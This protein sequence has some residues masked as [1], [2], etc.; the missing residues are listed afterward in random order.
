MSDFSERSEQIAA[1]L[2]GHATGAEIVPHD[3]DGRQGAV[4]FQLEWPDGRAGALE[5]TLVTELDSIQWQGMALKDGWSW[6][7]DT[8]WEFRPVNVSFHYKNTKRA[9]LRTVELCDQWSVEHPSSLPAEILKS[10]PEVAK[11]LADGVGHLR[12]TPFSPG[13]T[14]Y[15]ATTAEFIDAAPS[16]FARVVET[17]LEQPHVAPH[18]KKVKSATQHSERHL[19][20]VVMSEALP[21]RFF[22]DNF[23]EPAT[24]PQG[25]E[26]VDVLW[27]WSDYWQRYLAFKDGTWSWNQFPPKPDTST[28]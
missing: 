14:I 21:V 24:S 12:R 19:F 22:E 7:A 25:F 17:W 15:Q 28:T 10:E 8:S 13:I 18:L 26:G 16:D 20:V 9:A 2:V 5:V 6:K 4:D 27:V 11:F 1:H 3:T 23:E